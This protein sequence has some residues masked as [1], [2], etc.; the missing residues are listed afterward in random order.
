MEIVGFGLLAMQS[1]KIGRLLR[2]LD[3]LAGGSLGRSLLPRANQPAP[4]AWARL[5][6]QAP[7]VL[8]F[9]IVRNS[10]RPF[11]RAASHWADRRIGCF[12]LFFGSKHSAATSKTGKHTAFKNCQLK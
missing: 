5:R 6:L 11:S 3:D 1:D 4:N 10:D 9:S 8:C 7:P 2:F 12:S